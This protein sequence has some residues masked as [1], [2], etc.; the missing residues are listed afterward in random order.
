MG[1]VV[2]STVGPQRERVT[3]ASRRAVYRL[4][5]PAMTMPGLLPLTV[6]AA[7]R[8]AEGNERSTASCQVSL[9]IAQ[10]SKTSLDVE[11]GTIVAEAWLAMVARR[12]DEQPR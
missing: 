5:L 8:E 11:L 6:S 1:V 9:S 7:C 3:G 12:A 2:I 4:D 10:H